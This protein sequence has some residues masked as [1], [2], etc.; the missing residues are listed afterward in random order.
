MLT[1]KIS[2]KILALTCALLIS[3]SAF[4]TGIVLGISSKK[5]VATNVINDIPSQSQQISV[6]DTTAEQVAT[7]SDLKPNIDGEAGRFGFSYSLPSNAEIVKV[8]QSPI[9]SDV[10]SIYT[11]H[12]KQHIYLYYE[13]NGSTQFQIFVRV[14]NFKAQEEL[15]LGS[16]EET[17]QEQTT[18]AI[19]YNQ[20]EEFNFKVTIGGGY[21]AISANVKLGDK[22]SK[23]PILSFNP[24]NIYL[25]HGACNIIVSGRSSGTSSG[26]SFAINAD[27]SNSTIK[28]KLYLDDGVYDIK[29]V[30]AD[31][32]VFY[33]TSLNY[34]TPL[35]ATAVILVVLG[36]VGAAVIIVS[37]IILRTRMKVR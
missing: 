22:I 29:L 3:I 37:F 36:I 15:Q 6:F 34:S 11:D 32:T 35:N 18:T 4:I 30:G 12:D 16:E 9:G 21:P 2:F 1:K 14:N 25:Q 31:E 10:K 5:V 8:Y 17:E 33:W 19:T 27:S 13:K 7:A 20:I 24:Y 26:G 23:E 28:Q